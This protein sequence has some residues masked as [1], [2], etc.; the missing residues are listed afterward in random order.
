MEPLTLDKVLAEEN[1]ALGPGSGRVA[2]CLSGGGARSAIFSLGVL[3]GLARMDLLRRIDYLSTVGGGGWTGAWLSAWLARS[4]KPEEVWEMLA[5]VRPPGEFSPVE[6]L[7]QYLPY[8]N[9]FAADPA[10]WA[11]QALWNILIGQVLIAT[12][13]FALLMLPRLILELL[14]MRLPAAAAHTALALAAICAAACVRR[15]ASYLRKASPWPTVLAATAALGFC[16]AWSWYCRLLGHP[17]GYPAFAGVAAAV[18]AGGLAS[19]RNRDPRWHRRLVT[20]V[21]TVLAAVASSGGAYALSRLTTVP[22]GASALVFASFGPPMLLGTLLFSNILVG[23][24]TSFATLPD[25]RRRW[26]KLSADTLALALGWALLNFCTLYFPGLLTPL[27][28]TPRLWIFAGGAAATLIA[29]LAGY[30]ASTAA[31]VQ[32]LL[33]S[34]AGIP[35]LKAVPDL[36]A[37]LILMVAPY[38][39]LLWVLLMASV[40]SAR[41]ANSAALAMQGPKWTILLLASAVLASIGWVFGRFVNLNQFSLTA[42]YRDRLV[43]VFLGAS[44]PGREGLF[45]EFHD[46]DNVPMSKLTRRPLHIAN[47]ALPTTSLIGMGRSTTVAS[48]TVSPLHAGSPGLGYRKTGE[49]SAGHGI[50]LGTAMA[51]SGSGSSGTVGYSSSPVVRFLLT[52]FNARLGWWL[53][54]PGRAGAASWKSESRGNALAALWNDVSGTATVQ[55]PY[56]R[57]EDGGQHDALGIYQ[58][59]LR[60]C[61]TILVADAS[62]DPDFTFEELGTALRRIQVDL[63]IVVEFEEGQPARRRSALG[64]IR[65]SMVDG[66]SVQ[67]GHLLYFKPVVTGLEWVAIRAYAAKNPRFPYQ[68][69]EGKT[70]TDAQFEAYRTLGLQTVLEA[71]EGASTLEQWIA[72]SQAKGQAAQ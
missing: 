39:S 58:M 28:L 50:S 18:F 33:G 14:S 10:L 52:L 17:P 35:F 42:M 60:R 2:L 66:P 46:T 7:R 36:V 9:P 3:Q 70:L 26:I 41:L 71:L 23:S 53:P 15:A 69:L 20:G 68:I 30:S 25:E 31:G 62:D 56:V 59:V 67:D 47:L 4:G 13:L 27:G 32:Q 22:E 37:N 64:R 8:L 6:R 44:N 16:V 65:Y 51:I 55:K 38:F 61:P 43:A 19:R 48:F 57:C 24:I 34:V 54:N 11:T 49:Y 12:V 45:T 63:G 5:G 40:V 21:I 1:E 72:N 29:L